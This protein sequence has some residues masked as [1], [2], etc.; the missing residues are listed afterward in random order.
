MNP[1]GY[2]KFYRTM[3]KWEWYTDANT[4]RL[5]FHC[6]LKANYLDERVYGILVLRGS[7]LTSYEKLSTQTGLSIQNVRTSLNKLILTG[8]LTYKSTT[9]N[10]IITVNNYDL[11]QGDNTQTNKQLTNDQQ[12][13]NKQLTT[14]NKEKNLE[15]ENKEKKEYIKPL[16]DKMNKLIFDYTTNA[17]LQKALQEF[18]EFR[19]TTKPA[20]TELGF[21]KTLNTLDKLFATDDLQKIQAIDQSIENGWK[22]IFAIRSNGKA[23]NKVTYAWQEELKAE[24]DAEDSKVYEPKRTAKQTKDLWNKL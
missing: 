2:V 12:T 1:K 18:V 7:F 21:T 15:K 20:I 23:D 19:K 6:V 3:T 17:N 10:S 4:L 16:G 9:K 14:N 11:Y 5:F 8:E 22:G 24:Q 13:T